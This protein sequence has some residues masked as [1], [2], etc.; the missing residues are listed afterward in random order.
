MFN[1]F[2]KGPMR[3]LAR[4]VDGAESGRIVPSQIEQH[5]SGEHLRLAMI[6]GT[7]ETQRRL[8]TTPT[9][10]NPEPHRAR[11]S[12][13]W[14][15]HPAPG[16]D[17]A[18]GAGRFSALGDQHVKVTEEEE[19]TY[20]ESPMGKVLEH[21][22]NGYCFYQA[23]QKAQILNGPPSNGLNDCASK[24][25]DD[26][27][28][29]DDDSSEADSSS[30][31]M[32]RSP[33]PVCPPPPKSPVRAYSPILLEYAHAPE[34]VPSAPANSP[35]LSENT[36]ESVAQN[37]LDWDSLIMMLDLARQQ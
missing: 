30:T 23:L 27:N 15:K 31:S 9:A 20:H 10:D 28:S 19:K 13:P 2:P 24:S 12:F 14:N 17:Q 26:N 36:P 33:S 18:A 4:Y 29:S 16:D 37:T 32:L 5:E 6:S 3:E 35:I 22:V 25:S 1:I 34:F 8:Y 11:V 7:L 21:M